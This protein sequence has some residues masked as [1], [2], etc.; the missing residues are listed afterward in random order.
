MTYMSC[1]YKFH[2]NGYNKHNFLV[3]LAAVARNNI[4]I[5]IIQMNLEKTIT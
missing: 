3:L 1:L 2:P 4:R 5:Y